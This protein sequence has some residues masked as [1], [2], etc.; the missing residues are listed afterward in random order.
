VVAEKGSVGADQVE[1]RA[2]ED[3]TRLPPSVVNR[4]GMMRGG[5]T[6]AARR[7]TQ[8]AQGA[9]AAAQNI[10]ATEVRERREEQAKVL[11][12]VVRQVIAD[13]REL[14]DLEQRQHEHRAVQIAAAAVRKATWATTKHSRV[15]AGRLAT[16]EPEA[17]TPAGQQTD[18]EWQ[19]AVQQFDQFAPMELPTE[20]TLTPS[21]E[22]GEEVWGGETR[23]ALVG[24]P[25]TATDGSDG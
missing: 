10:Q 13:V 21:V 17:V 11:R 18:V 25:A 4:A 15:I 19:A 5:T 6:T 8:R 16:P 12:V 23:E 14:E 2:S 3:D 9:V 24:P 1:E 22:R 20:G 7:R